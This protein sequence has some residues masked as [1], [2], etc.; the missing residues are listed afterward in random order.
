[1]GFLV[2]NYDVKVVEYFICIEIDE[3]VYLWIYFGFIF[4]DVNNFV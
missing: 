3:L 4:E 2:M 1:M